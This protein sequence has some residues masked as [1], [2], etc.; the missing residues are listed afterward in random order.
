MDL[1]INKFVCKEIQPKILYYGMPIFLLSTLNEDGT[2]NVSPMSSSWALGNYIIL[3]IG[4]GGKAIQNL[5]INKECV[6]NLPSSLQWEQ[7]E[8]IAPFTG[9]ENVPNFKQDMGYTYKK[10]KV[11]VCDFTLIDSTKIQPQRIVEC[12]IQIEAKVKEI[13]IP[14]YAP[15]FA[16]VETEVVHVHAHNEII[17]SENHIDPLKWKPLFY[18]FRHYFSIGKE[19]GENYRA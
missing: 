11:S 7:V 2:T 17:K 3:G 19:L 4:L 12:P 5:E 9:V 13:H 18:N 8:K 10:D 16:I 1:K 15:F 6:V 14:E